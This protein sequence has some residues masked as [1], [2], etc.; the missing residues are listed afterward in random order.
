MSVRENLK[1]LTTDVIQMGFL[2]FL[3]TFQ[4]THDHFMQKNMPNLCFYLCHFGLKRRQFDKFFDKNV[5]KCQV[6]FGHKWS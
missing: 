1:N 4:I 5:T 2:V 3:S 6:N